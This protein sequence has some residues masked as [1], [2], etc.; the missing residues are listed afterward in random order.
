[1]LFCMLENVAGVTHCLGGAAE[2]F[3]AT[4]LAIVRV[5]LPMFEWDHH[6]LDALDYGLAQS[7][8]RVFLIGMRKEV[9]M[10]GVLPVP[11][12]PFGRTP[13]RAFLK[14]GLP[15]TLRNSLT[16]C[17]AKNWS[18]HEEIVA[19][20]QLQAV[21]DLLVSFSSATSRSQFDEPLQT[22]LWSRALFE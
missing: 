17:M 7:R 15:S 13:L 2:S 22:V 5:R 1:M 14:V 20:P 16:R 12:P 10:T 19:Q 8:V 11:L 21:I 9:L 6:T 4:V 3:M 18:E